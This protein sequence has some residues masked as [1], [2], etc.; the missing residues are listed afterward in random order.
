MVNY[1]LMIPILVSFF[2]TLFMIPSWIKRARKANL[3]GKDINKFK[4]TELPEAGGVTVVT[5]FVLGSLLY[6]ALNTFIFN[7]SENFI[8]LF[9]LLSTILLI[10]FI[11]FVDDIL[12]WKIGLRKRTRLIL[13]ALAAI[14]LIVIN[15]G[16][17]E[18]GIPLLGTIDL[19]LIYPLIIIP[20]GIIGATTTFNFLA[21]FNGLEAG[22]GILLMFAVGIVAFFI[23]SPWLTII[24]LCM[25]A[26]LLAFL[27]YNFYPAKVYPGDSLTYAVGGLIDII[28][29]L[30]NFEKIAVFFFITYIIETGLKLRG[31]LVK[32]FFGKTK[33]DGSLELAYKKIYS[34]NHIAI[35]LMKKLGWKAT[36]KRVVYFIWG[37][38][39]LI[40]ILGFIIFKNGIF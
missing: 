17:S 11:A 21:G 18:V 2:V 26:A 38:Q 12:G 3:L 16:E 8:E 32:Q 22:Q 35:L 10:T 27:L 14:P 33:K 4:K 28:A 39:I 13:V 37:F 9:A 24:A 5:G 7:T 20:I 15:A 36:E 31:K 29:I 1:I 19:G 23:G 6:I 30:G 40:I 25:A 34:L